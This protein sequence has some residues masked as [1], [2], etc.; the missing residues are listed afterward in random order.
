ME[1]SHQTNK[2]NGNNL[3]EHNQSRTFLSYVLSLGKWMCCDE[4]NASMTFVILKTLI[5]TCI[6]VVKFKS[7]S[8]WLSV[9]AF[10]KHDT[11]SV[12][13]EVQNDARLAQVKVYVLRYQV[14][15][16]A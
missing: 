13:S 12:M 3:D 15:G 16:G 8:Y 6:K 5:Q 9:V 1:I 2:L 11:C 14:T 4:G 10:R 7:M